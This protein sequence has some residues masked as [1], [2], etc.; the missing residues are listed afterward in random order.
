MLGV[1]DDVKSR[2]TLRG[3]P[4]PQ[5]LERLQSDDVWPSDTT[6]T[7]WTARLWPIRNT[8]EDATRAALLTDDWLGEK[9]S[10]ADILQQ[11]D[12]AAEL[13]WRD[14]LQEHV[15]STVTATAPLRID[16][17]GGWSDTPPICH[18]AG[19]A[20]CNVAV[21][22][23]GKRPVGCRCSPL[24]RKE[25]ILRIEDTQTCVV[26]SLEDL[27]DRSDPRAPCALLK[28]ALVVAGVV[29]VD[30]PPLQEQLHQGLELT[31][32]SRVPTGSGLGTSSILAACAVAVLRDGSRQQLVEDATARA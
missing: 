30:G 4:F 26:T 2:A 12:R 8:P 15:A 23:D 29:D 11:A 13:A 3:E 25:L 16:L 31:S 32:W 5:V 6:K 20:V 22:L 18:E 9:L 14:A 24:A 21:K 10:L 1:K 19:G 28:C 27:G 7:L 17:A